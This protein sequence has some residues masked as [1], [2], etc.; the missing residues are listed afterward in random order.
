[1]ARFEP[2]LVWRPGRYPF[3]D[4]AIEVLEIDIACWRK[5]RPF[6]SG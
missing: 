3:R 5:I 6:C 4:G 1:M 2:G